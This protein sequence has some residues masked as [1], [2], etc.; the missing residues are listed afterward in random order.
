MNVIL[1]GNGNLSHAFKEYATNNSSFNIVDIIDEKQDVKNY[2]SVDV[3]IDFSYK[4]AILTSLNLALKY[5]ATLII[6]TTNYNVEQ[7]NLIK[8]LSSK[9]KIGMSNNFSI[10]FY[11][12]KLINKLLENTNLF[13]DKYVIETHQ[14]L[15]KDKPSGSSLELANKEDIISLRGSSINGEHEIRYFFDNEEIEVKHLIHS[16]RAFVD[17]VIKMIS[18]LKDKP[19]GLYSFEDYMKEIVSGN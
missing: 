17:G 7:I 8:Q 12:T 18:Y 9:I 16:R 3:I 10:G 15:K 1:I 19:N 14:K 13:K 6:G 11:L 2:K 5:N 4:D